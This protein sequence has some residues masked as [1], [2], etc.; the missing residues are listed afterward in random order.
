M[1]QPQQPFNH[2]T[3]PAIREVLTNT[4]REPGDVARALMRTLRCV[5]RDSHD[6]TVPQQ[7]V[8]TRA[9]HCI[10]AEDAFKRRDMQSAVE[11]L[12]AV[13]DDAPVLKLPTRHLSI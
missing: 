13:W 11:A 9:Q 2:V 7:S 1:S 5:M 12:R 10:E 8:E 4:T 3:D 6:E